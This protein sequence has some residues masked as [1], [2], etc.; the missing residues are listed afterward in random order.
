MR[1]NVGKLDSIIRIVLGVAALGA[2][3]F[4][5]SVLAYLVGGVLALTALV[6]FCPL[7]ALL[8]L[9]TDKSHAQGQTGNA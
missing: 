3:Y 9:H 7:Y 4:Y 1:A 5:S 8:G 2:G 6:G